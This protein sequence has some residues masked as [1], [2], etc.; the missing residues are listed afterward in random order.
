M[1]TNFRLNTLTVL[2]STL[3]CGCAQTEGYRD[4]VQAQTAVQSNCNFYVDAA[5]V[6]IL[7]YAD[8]AM[9]PC[10][11]LDGRY[12]FFNN[13]NAADAKTHI[14]FARRVS[15]NVF[16]YSGLLPG[17]NSESKDMAPSVDRKGNFYFTSLRTFDKDGRS[18]WVGQ[19][20]DGVVRNVRSVEGEIAHPD[21]PGAINMDCCISPDGQ[22]LI[23]SRAQFIPGLSMPINSKLLMCEKQTDGRFQK[24]PYSALLTKTT[25]NLAYAPAMTA[26]NN[27]I[28][29]T[30]ADIPTR[31]LQT[32]MVL[33]SAHGKVS[34]KPARVT[35]IEGFAEAVSITL[36]KGELFFHK[37]DGPIY[38]I[39]RA[40]RR[41]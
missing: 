11:S 4:S 9:E 40:Q 5:P 15:A 32:C 36:N 21:F 25:G 30:N 20:K 34:T 37:K 18:I 19:L 1:R 8:D 6:Q 17:V 16:E 7:N 2:L 38:R 23:V 41:S 13:S 10:I 31:T 27:E 24:T 3:V 12:L 28:Y 39:Y 14:H 22:V 35:A 33:L 26:D 29:Y